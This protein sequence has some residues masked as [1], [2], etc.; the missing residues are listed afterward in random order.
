M[1]PA[2]HSRVPSRLVTWSRRG[3]GVAAAGVS[4]AAC[5]AGFDDVDGSF[6]VLAYSAAEAEAQAQAQA[7]AE[8]GEAA[9]LRLEA[10]A[11]AEVA[12]EAAAAAAPLA[13][14]AAAPLAYGGGF[15]EDAT[16]FVVDDGLVV[17]ANGFYRPAPR[18]ADDTATRAAASAAAASAS[19]AAASAAARDDDT[20][21]FMSVPAAIPYAVGLS[22]AANVAAVVPPEAPSAGQIYPSFTMQNRQVGGR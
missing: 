3:R 4:H 10:E 20:S 22:V 21:S 9:V 6:E 15:F 12:A 14:A 13:P 17:L 5:T 1:S 18:A 19:A 8:A 7:Q 16:D 2:C 11:A